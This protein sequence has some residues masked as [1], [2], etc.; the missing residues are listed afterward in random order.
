M[1]LMFGAVLGN[2]ECIVSLISL[3]ETPKIVF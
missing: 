1:I 3:G 2:L